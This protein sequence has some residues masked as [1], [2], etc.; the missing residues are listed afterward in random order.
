MTMSNRILSV[1]ALPLAM[2]FLVSCTTAG[3][4]SNVMDEQEISYPP[5]DGPKK[6]IAVLEFDNKV[7]NRWWDRSWNI[8]DRLTEMVI[9]ELMKTNRFIVVERGSL[10]EV[11]SEQDLGA[12]GRVRQET[13]AK[14]GEVLGAQ[15]LLKGAITEFIE[16]ESGGAGGILIG[17]IGIGGKTSTGH[18][19]MDLRLIDA[20]TGQILQSE[21][22]EGKISSS[23]I[24]G[25]AFFSGVAFGGTSYKK[26]ALGKATRAAVSD[27]VMFVVNNM[28]DQPWQGM[29]VK[30]EGNQIYINAGYNMNI[31]M[32][33]V[34]TVYS[35]GEDLIDPGSGLS[36]GSALSRS[37]TVRVTQ[38]S[39]KFSIASSIEG[40]GFKR[41]DVV[42]LQ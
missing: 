7:N 22:A 21:R 39:D 25:I 15:V 28:E 34:F 31:Q 3:G 8:E 4:N 29:V 35:K 26:T 6:R 11:L 27:A 32:D 19:A 38:V 41:G 24:G 13:A 12:S 5:Y 16:K 18:V 1:F 23:G 33:S 10:N 20:T 42:K 9:T 2:L 30:A 17:G 37:G 36:L 14:I 40:S